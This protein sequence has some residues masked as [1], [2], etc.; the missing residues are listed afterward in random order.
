MSKET[1]FVV[2]QLKHDLEERPDD[3]NCNDFTIKDKKT[4]FTYWICSGAHFAGVYEPFKM[5][6]GFIQGLRFLSAVKKW[7]T[8]QMIKKSQESIECLKINEG[9][10]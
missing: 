7:Q 10:N 5:K 9:K 3:F 1:K 2:N 6:F 8:I 4:G